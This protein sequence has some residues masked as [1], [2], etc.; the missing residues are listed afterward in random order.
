[1]TQKAYVPN[2]TVPVLPIC[3]AATGFNGWLTMNLNVSLLGDEAK[4]LA[5][6]KSTKCAPLSLS[7]HTRIYTYDS[8]SFNV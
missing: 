7:T 8:S 1:M 5:A 4:Q 3:F 2:N 6:Q